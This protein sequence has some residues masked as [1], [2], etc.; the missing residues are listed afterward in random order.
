MAQNQ[1]DLKCEIC[2]KGG[3]SLYFAMHKDFNRVVRMCRD[4]WIDAYVK[5]RLVS[6]SG[7]S[8]GGCACSG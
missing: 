7:G 3:V 2:G 4:C 6:D 5:N 1:D 8:S